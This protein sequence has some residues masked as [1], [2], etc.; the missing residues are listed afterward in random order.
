[1][2]VKE[3]AP[4]PDSYR[5]SGRL[6]FLEEKNYFVFTIFLVSTILPFTTGSFNKN[7]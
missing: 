4:W 6:P 2:A 3:K 5:D 7:M 1:M